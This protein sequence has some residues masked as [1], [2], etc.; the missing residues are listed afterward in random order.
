MF[1]IIQMFSPHT[2]DSEWT[3][4]FFS[5][6]NAAT[7][8]TTT[9]TS[10]LSR[11]LALLWLLLVA[12]T[13]PTTGTNGDCWLTCDW[14]GIY[15]FD[16]YT[17]KQT[18]VSCCDI[19][20][21]YNATWIK[22][23]WRS[24]QKWLPLVL[25]TH[26]FLNASTS[27]HGW[28]GKPSRWQ[29]AS[30]FEVIFGDGKLRGEKLLQILENEDAGRIVLDHHHLLTD[31]TGIVCFTYL[32]SSV[33]VEFISILVGIGTNK[34]SKAFIHPFLREDKSTLLFN[35]ISI[36]WKKAKSSEKQ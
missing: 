33:T 7:T 36:D 18:H 24:S 21:S 31:D 4:D 30:E 35:S 27:T 25:Q 29:L 3:V 13:T 10:Q 11:P 17:S 15:I 16:R 9:T 14:L 1:H 22:T 23:Q 28:F 34:L 12:T 6:T 8:S 5:R 20:R 2:H 26:I 32:F 19:L